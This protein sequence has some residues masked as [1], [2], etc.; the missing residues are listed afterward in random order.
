VCC[1]LQAAGGPTPGAAP[2]PPPGVAAGAKNERGWVAGYTSL[3]ATRA[4]LVA[5]GWKPLEAVVRV[6]V[7]KDHS[8]AVVRVSVAARGAAAGAGGSS[9]GKGK[10][11]RGEGATVE[12]KLRMS[13]EAEATSFLAAYAAARSRG[14]KVRRARRCDVPFWGSALVCRAPHC[15]KK[16]PD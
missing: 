15:G 1:S 8:P 5:H 7:K 10:G 4:G 12:Y 11:K 13:S 3:L 14:T 16:A 6:G 9:K 2:K